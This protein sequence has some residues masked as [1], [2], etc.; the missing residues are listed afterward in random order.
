MNGN[1]PPKTTKKNLEMPMNQFIDPTV[2]ETIWN[3][4]DYSGDEK[5]ILATPKTGL[6]SC[7]IC[8]ND[9]SATRKPPGWISLSCLHEPSVCCDCLAQCIKNDLESKIWNQ[10]A[11]PECKTLLVHED[12][13]RLADTETFAKHV[14]PTILK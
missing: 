1:P 11:C 13:G 10:I 3:I 12:I 8:T 7:I 2:E 14:N 4:Y 9:F 5:D 6:M